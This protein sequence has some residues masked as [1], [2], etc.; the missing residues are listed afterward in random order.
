MVYGLLETVYP[1]FHILL[2][3][4]VMSLIYE[5]G[6]EWK[7]KMNLIEKMFNYSSCFIESDDEEKMNDEPQMDKKEI[8]EKYE[9]KYLERLRERTIEKDI[10][11][12]P[13]NGQELELEKVLYDELI[14]IFFKD[15]EKKELE[16]RSELLHYEVML[17][18][19]DKLAEYLS[20]TLCLDEDIDELIE[21]NRDHAL[22]VVR[23]KIDDINKNLDELE[24]LKNEGPNNDEFHSESHKKIITK[25]L[26]T[27]KNT[28]I[29]EKTPLG[30]VIMCW[31][32]TRKS[33]VYYSDNTIPYRY[34]E[35]VGRKYVLT[36]NCKSVFFDMETEVKKAEERLAQEKEKEK[37]KEREKEKE[38][39]KMKEEEANINTNKKDVFAKFKNYNKNNSKSSVATGAAPKNNINMQNNDSTKKDEKVV[40]KENANRYTNEGK[41]A[42]FNILK[43]VDKKVFNKRL[44]MSF[45]EFKKMQMQNK[46]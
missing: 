21:K 43:R 12:L 33:F 13:F 30:N 46:K 2:F 6:P 16:L 34:L 23:E 31:D 4:Y 42:N 44:E 25:R 26:E 22:N 27:L 38:N 24:C 29:I 39:E 40:L 17:D 7:R 37:E 36:H 15:I 35:A 18:D 9:N 8:Q 45:S 1:A 32:E 14:S 3:F 11:N 41:I 28:Y 19:D 5:F 10:S 20:D